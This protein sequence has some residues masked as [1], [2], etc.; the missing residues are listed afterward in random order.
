MFYEI[1]TNKILIIPICAWAIAQ[2]MKVIIVLIRNKQLDL[3]YLVISSGMPS[4]HSAFV[5]ALA[6]SVAL[7]EGLGSVV[8]GI[9]T[10]LALVVIYDAAG[11]RRSVGQQSVA[12]NRILHELRLRRPVA[13]LGHDLREF[14]G[15]TQ[16]QVLV[17]VLVGITVALK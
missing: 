3:R 11:V 12:L 2:S 14:I 17:G 7:I 15:H 10:I 4:S 8:F 6:T 16:F 13:E 1:I 9:S 5:S